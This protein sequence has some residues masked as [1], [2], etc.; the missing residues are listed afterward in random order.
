MTKRFAL[1]I[2]SR[3]HSPPAKSHPTIRPPDIEKIGD[4]PAEVRCVPCDRIV[5][6][7]RIK[8]FRVY[9]IYL[10]GTC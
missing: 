4:R 8:H 10:A 3:R 2:G 7:N 1:P 5:R 6:H 9:R